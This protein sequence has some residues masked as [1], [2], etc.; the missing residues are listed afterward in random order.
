MATNIAE[1]YGNAWLCRKCPHSTKLQCSATSHIGHRFCTMQ[2]VMRVYLGLQEERQMRRKSF[3]LHDY[4][5]PA[6]SHAIFFV[7]PTRQAKIWYSKVVHAVLDQGIGE[8]PGCLRFMGKLA[9]NQL[10]AGSQQNLQI[11]T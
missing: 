5:Q 11:L 10:S 7:L 3:P 9:H 6:S 8:L 1:F 2:V 4:L